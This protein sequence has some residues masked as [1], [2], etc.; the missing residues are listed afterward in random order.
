M[1][2]S[3]NG[4]VSKPK[5]WRNLYCYIEAIPSSLDDFNNPYFLV[6]KGSRSLILD[7]SKAF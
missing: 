7:Y 2:K 5:M 6:M 4:E 3:P 1:S